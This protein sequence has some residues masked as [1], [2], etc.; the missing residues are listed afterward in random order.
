MN[1]P[2]DDS[3]EQVFDDLRQL[4]ARQAK[5]RDARARSPLGMLRSGLAVAA[6]HLI[7]LLESRTIVVLATCL[8]IVFV[9]LLMQDPQRK[10]GFTDLIATSKIDQRAAREETLDAARSDSN[11]G[12]DF[13]PD[14]AAENSRSSPREERL[15]A[16][17]N[18]AFFVKV[19]AFR[20]PSNAKR[21]VE[22]LRKQTLEVKT[23]VFGGGLYVVTL[24][25]FS[26]KGSAEEIARTVH[27]AMGL[28][29]EILR[30]KF[31]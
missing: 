10:N 9:A 2:A 18:D 29:P 28:A 17:T 26:Q 5:M 6:G 25:P 16:K 23:E 24:G 21:I 4:M 27:D 20:D 7:P 11:A 15:I 14:E 12:A 22:Q 3:K 13:R 31:E 30:Q 19:G 8:S 1:I